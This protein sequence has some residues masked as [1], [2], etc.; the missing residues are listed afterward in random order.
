MYYKDKISHCEECLNK[1]TCTKCEKN[2]YLSNDY[3]SCLI[4]SEITNYCKVIKKVIPYSNN[5]LN[6]SLIEQNINSFILDIN[7]S[8]NNN[9]V[10]HLIN[11][12]YNYS[13]LIFKSS[14]CTYSLLKDGYYYINNDEI[15]EKLFEYPNIDI[16]NY[17]FCFINYKE[18]K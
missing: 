10:H 17:I 1:N 4:S 18:K 8:D 12:N 15:N 11:H 3:S 6:I 9:I 16:N 14:V 5:K 13:I 7:K 2:F